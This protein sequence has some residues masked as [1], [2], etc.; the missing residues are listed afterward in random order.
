[1][2]MVRLNTRRLRRRQRSLEDEVSARTDELRSAY[3][4]LEAVSRTD[5]L[6]A[7]HNRRHAMEE[8]PARL[9]RMKFDADAGR[10]G[11]ADQ[12]T[13]VALLDLDHFK[14]IND[15]YGHQAGDQVLQEVAR[16]LSA[17]KRHDDMLV[18]WGGEEFLLVAF[19]VSR[20]QVPTIAE[21][22][23][24]AVRDSAIMIPGKPLPVTASLG[25]VLVPFTRQALEADWDQMVHMADEALYRA[26]QEGRDCWRQTPFFTT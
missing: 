12:G 26:K 8:M 13:M 5:A 23:C 7:I 1:V 20:E 11:A 17:Q 16:R 9:R 25:V 6:T 22:V 24:S 4:R 14:S 3:Q 2:L 19:G 10:G 21:R 18:R 15:T